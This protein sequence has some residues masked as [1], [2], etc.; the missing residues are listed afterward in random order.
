MQDEAKALVGRSADDMQKLKEASSPEFDEVL[1]AVKCKFY[2]VKLRISEDT[3]QDEQR[4]RINMVRWAN[5]TCIPAHSAPESTAEY[6]GARARCCWTSSIN[7][8][9]H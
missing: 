8:C 3:W 6:M 4:I 2:I 7:R 5:S 9:C 1:N